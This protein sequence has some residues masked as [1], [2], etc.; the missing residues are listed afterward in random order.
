MT[1][2][3][4][5]SSKMVCAARICKENASSKISLE[6]D[7]EANSHNQGHHHK[8]YFRRPRPLG[9]LAGH[10]TQKGP[11][12]LVPLGACAASLF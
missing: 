11:T 8:D 10:H 6:K 12:L 2:G 9:H 7:G 1:S 5:N 3:K 4:G